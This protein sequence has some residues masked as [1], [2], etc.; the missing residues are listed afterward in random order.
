[1]LEISK[2]GMSTHQLTLAWN[3]KGNFGFCYK[4][5]D[6]TSTEKLNQKNFRKTGQKSRNK[7]LL[8]LNKWL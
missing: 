7:Y 6:K 2:T 3:Y 1:M 5:G 4:T 8:Y